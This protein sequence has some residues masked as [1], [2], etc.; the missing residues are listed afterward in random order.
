VA[1]A[2]KRVFLAAR[3]ESQPRQGA[4]DLSAVIR[5]KARRPQASVVETAPPGFYGAFFPNGVESR[6]SNTAG[7][8]YGHAIGIFGS[9]KCVTV[10]TGRETGLSE[11]GPT[12]A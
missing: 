2:G 1:H 4:S 9:F 6:V 12:R 10:A 11:S 3:M 5:D 7:A 8:R